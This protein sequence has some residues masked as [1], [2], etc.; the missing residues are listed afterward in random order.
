[1]TSQNSYIPELSKLGL[2]FLYRIGSRFILI[3][4]HFS[5][6]EFISAPSSTDGD[7]VAAGTGNPIKV[8]KKAQTSLANLLDSLIE[9]RVNMINQVRHRP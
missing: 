6:V 8:A 2:K 9:L 4:V 3:D 5:R 1:M 7:D